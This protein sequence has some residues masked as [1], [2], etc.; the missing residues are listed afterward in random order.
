MLASPIRPRARLLY[1]P[2]LS[3]ERK[4]EASVRRPLRPRE[5]TSDDQHWEH[6]RG[7]A[8]ATWRLEMGTTAMSCQRGRG[9]R[10]R[11]ATP[12]QRARRGVLSLHSQ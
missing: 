3:L 2:S 11:R 4:Q 9:Q 7:A 8:C 10:N 12:G 1:G 6:T 5:T